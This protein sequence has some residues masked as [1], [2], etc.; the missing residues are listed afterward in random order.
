[1]DQEGI[2]RGVG[3]NNVKMYWTKK[4]T[5]FKKEETRERVEQK[6]GREWEWGKLCK[7]RKDCSI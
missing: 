5:I 6:E 4:K 7:M 2:R 1:M 3:V